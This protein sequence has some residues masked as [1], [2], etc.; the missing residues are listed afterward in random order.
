MVGGMVERIAPGGSVKHIV[1]QNGWTLCNKRLSMWSSQAG[2]GE[3]APC[4]KCANN[5]RKLASQ[6]THFAEGEK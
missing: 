6:L 4:K 2:I 3:V 1:K 5:A